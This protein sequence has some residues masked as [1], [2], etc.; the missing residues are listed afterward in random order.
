MGSG[1]QLV[2]KLVELEEEKE[3]IWVYKLE[4][5]TYGEHFALIICYLII[6]KIVV[7]KMERFNNIEDDNRYIEYNIT[8]HDKQIFPFYL[9]T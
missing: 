3:K 7:S 2:A 5:A 8:G 4:C 9:P 1:R 6:H